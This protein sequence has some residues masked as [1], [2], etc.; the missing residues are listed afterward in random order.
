MK[1]GNFNVLELSGPLQVCNGTALPFY[2][3]HTALGPERNETALRHA[4][5]TSV[6]EHSLSVLAVHLAKRWP[7]YHLPDVTG[8]CTDKSVG[9]Q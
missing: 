5:K 6:E 9:H 4:G 2:V 1:S 7:K 3:S 8:K